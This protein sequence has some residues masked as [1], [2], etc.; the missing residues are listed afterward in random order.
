MD[1][2]I[3]PSIV[4]GWE[5]PIPVD[6]SALIFIYLCCFPVQPFEKPVPS[7]DMICP[8]SASTA[9]TSEIIHTKM[10][11]VLL[12]HTELFDFEMQLHTY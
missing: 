5:V 6:S 7:L 2:P 9:F 11:F 8:L 10:I 12:E 3:C 4:H 1:I